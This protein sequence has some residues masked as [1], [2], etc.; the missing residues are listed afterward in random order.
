MTQLHNYH[1]TKLQ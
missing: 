1:T